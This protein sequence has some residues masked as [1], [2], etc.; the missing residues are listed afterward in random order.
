MIAPEADTNARNGLRG[1]CV[2]TGAAMAAC[3][4][5][6]WVVAGGAVATT[7]GV[8]AVSSASVPM[9][10]AI[11]CRPITATPVTSSTATIQGSGAVQSTEERFGSRDTRTGAT[12]TGNP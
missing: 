12:A 10:R 7:D 11:G 8:R 4:G 9:A 6:A 3:A 1:A 2:G 5:A